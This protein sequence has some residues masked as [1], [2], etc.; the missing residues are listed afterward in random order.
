MDILSH[1]I[2]MILVHM[3]DLT[4]KIVTLDRECD[5]KIKKV[6]SATLEAEREA[7]ALAESIKE[8]KQHL[9]EEQKN[10]EAALLMQEMKEVRK[11]AIAALHQKMEIFNQEV[12]ADKVVEHLLSTA[13]DRVCR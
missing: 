5:T 13:R 2:I 6:N 8:K 4:Q 7:D 12:T 9:L 11:K 3:M 1:I 10:T